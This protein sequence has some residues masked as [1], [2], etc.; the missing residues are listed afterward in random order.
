M[1]AS[2]GSFTNKGYEEYITGPKLINAIGRAGRAAKETEGVVVLAL[3]KQVSPADFQRFTPNPAEMAITSNMATQHALEML[4]DFENRIRESEDEIFQA[5]DQIISKFL[6]FIWYF[7]FEIE[8]RNEMMNDDKLR[9]FLGK[10]LAWVQLDQDSQSRWFSIAQKVIVKYSITEVASRRRWARSGTSLGSA[11][12]L[13]GIASEVASEA[14][15]LKTPIL[16]TDFI[17]IILDKNRINRIL[18]FQNAH[19]NVFY[20]LIWPK[21]S[22]NK[23][24]NGR[25][26][27]ELDKR[28]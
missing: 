9:Q 7:A 12:I 15:V 27:A 18:S 23:N 17:K 16:F 25:H 26:A 24:T 21:P 14:G 28:R 22:G 1:I 13:E 8:K 5:S 10:T 19:T 3:N 11:Q 2:Q 4:A 20:I 6:S